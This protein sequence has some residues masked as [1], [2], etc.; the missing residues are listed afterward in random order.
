[1]VISCSGMGY[2]YLHSKTRPQSV[3][4]YA[5]NPVLPLGAFWCTLAFCRNARARPSQKSAILLNKDTLGQ[6][7]LSRICQKEALFVTSLSLEPVRCC[8]KA[9]E[10]V[11]AQSS[12][13]FHK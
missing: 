3:F 13:T 12:Q 9:A 11:A 2:I 4:A 10:L 7:V 1:M 8:K 5:R 6:R